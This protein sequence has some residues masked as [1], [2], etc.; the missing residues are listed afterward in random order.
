MLCLIYSQ[1]KYT[2]QT[3]TRIHLLEQQQ[4]RLHQNVTTDE[5]AKGKRGWSQVVEQRAEKKIVNKINT[6]YIYVKFEMWIWNFLLV[7]I[8][9]HIKIELTLGEKAVKPSPQSS[10]RSSFFW[11]TTCN[12]N[13]NTKWNGFLLL[14][15]C[16]L[17]LLVLFFDEF[18]EQVACVVYCTIYSRVKTES[19]SLVLRSRRKLKLST[20]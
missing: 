4:Q 20:W 1:F 5:H 18:K 7:C 3:S 17:F 15:S 8:W 14:L 12:M 13:V 16:C 2:Q 11:W 10:L 6:K 19:K 9:K